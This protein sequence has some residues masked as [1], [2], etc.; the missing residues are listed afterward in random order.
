MK[1]HYVFFK[2]CCE[3]YNRLNFKN[4]LKGKKVK[5]K[6]GICFIKGLQII[7]KG[8]DNEIIIEDFVRIKQSRIIIYG[9][10]NKINIKDFAALNQ[11]EL[12]MEDDNN[13][14]LI[15]ERTN[16]CGKAHLATIEGTKILIGNDCLFSS[17]LH[18]TT[19]DSHSILNLQG[20]RINPS[21][22]IIIEDH[23][24]VGTRVTCLKGVRVSKNSI[25][26]ATTTLCKKY[27]TENVVIGGVPGK[28]IKT[29]VNWKSERI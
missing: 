11:I 9:N 6:K 14:I 27:D 3:I 19:G 26:A 18:F 5:L 28:I 29:G 1:K 21:S 12:Y 10:H 20:E 16:L 23:V 17:N 8:L 22:D 7:N 13:E 24:W 25:V 15:G 2:I 4:R